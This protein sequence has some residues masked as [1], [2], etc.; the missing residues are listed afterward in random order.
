M[1]QDTNNDVYPY[2]HYTFLHSRKRAS[3]DMGPNNP[4]LEVLADLMPMRW[5]CYSYLQARIKRLHDLVEARC[6]VLQGEASSLSCRPGI[7]PELASLSIALQR[8]QQTLDV[9]ATEHLEECTWLYYAY[10]TEYDEYITKHYTTFALS[11]D[12]LLH[13]TKKAR[14]SFLAEQARLA[15][16]ERWPE[17]HQ[18]V[19]TRNALCEADARVPLEP[20]QPKP[21]AG[22]TLSV[23][24]SVIPTDTLP[25]VSKTSSMPAREMVV[26]HTMDR[27][28]GPSWSPAITIRKGNEM[29][30]SQGSPMAGAAP[31]LS[32][33]TF[34]CSP[35][36]PSAPA[37]STKAGPLQPS[38]F[39]TAPV[40]LQEARAGAP[41]SL[42]PSSL[43]QESNDYE[44]ECTLRSRAKPKE[45]DKVPG[46]QP[47][48]LLLSKPERARPLA[49]LSV[50]PLFMLLLAHLSAHRQA[51]ISNGV[52]SR[53]SVK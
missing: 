4:T 53:S 15:P 48:E 41:F 6:T 47:R 9:Q 37:N 46:V 27:A 16:H 43:A 17:F 50:G 28:T 14:K 38:P 45:P 25:K 20:A 13:K 26:K 31:L 39:E 52:L 24:A 32:T 2:K 51:G 44:Y 1:R 5:R 34:A 49:R 3:N 21:I 30:V 7:A 11:E 10:A 42:I 22:S 36:V 19:E 8:F 18:A 23:E 33:A 35:Q 12:E 40:I 29:N